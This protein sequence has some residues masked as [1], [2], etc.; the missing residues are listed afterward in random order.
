ME[1]IIPYLYLW[2]CNHFEK[3]ILIGVKAYNT[4]LLTHLSAKVYILYY[5]QKYFRI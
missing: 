1:V 2:P 3:M 4:L 5:D